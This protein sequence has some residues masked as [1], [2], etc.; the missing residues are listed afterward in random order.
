MQNSAKI[1][2]VNVIATYKGCARGLGYK[3]GRTTKINPFP[4]WL[5]A[6][7]CGIFT[8]LKSAPNNEKGENGRVCLSRQPERKQ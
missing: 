6:Q 1:K 4:S 2:N 5:G 8:A 7:E 3:N